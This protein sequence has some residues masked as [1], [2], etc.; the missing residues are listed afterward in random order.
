MLGTSHI[1]VTVRTS[2]G[3]TRKRVTSSTCPTKGEPVGDP[4]RAQRRGGRGAGVA[5]TVEA[6][7]DQEKADNIKKGSLSSP[8]RV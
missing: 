4:A 2:T 7:L 5:Y 3:R 1:A 6:V 8:Q